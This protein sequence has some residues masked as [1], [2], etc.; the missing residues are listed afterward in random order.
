MTSIINTR[1]PSVVVT[2]TE[3]GYTKLKTRFGNV[4]EDYD[5]SSIGSW[6]YPAASTP[7][8]AIYVEQSFDPANRIVSYAGLQNS[9]AYVTTLALL[10]DFAKGS[11]PLIQAQYLVGTSD[12]LAFTTTN[13]STVSPINITDIVITQDE[14]VV[15][16]PF[17]SANIS[18]TGT[19]DLL[20]I[21]TIDLNN[22][23]AV[24]EVLATVPVSGSIVVSIPGGT[25][26][27][28]YFSTKRFSDGDTDVSAYTSF[29][30][31]IVVETGLSAPPEVTNSSLAAY[32]TKGT[33]PGYTLRVDWDYPTD[34]ASENKRRN[35]T[36]TLLANPA[37]STN[38]E[39]LNWSNAIAE[40]AIDTGYVYSS[41]PYQ[42]SY[43]IRIGVT[44]WGTEGSDYIYIPVYISKD[45]ADSGLLG[46]LIPS[47]QEYSGTTKIQI[48]DEFIRAYKVFDASN[49]ANNIKVFDVDANTGN[50]VIGTPG[51]TYNGSTMTTAPFI[52][53]STSGRLQVSGR[54]ITDQIESA[55]YVLS[56]IDATPPSLRTAGKA[57][58]AAT[59]AGIWMGYT[60]LSTFKFDLGNASNYVRWDGTD[61][62]ISGTVKIG[63]D[64]RTVGQAQRQ[65][66]VYKRSTTTPATPTDGTYS[67]PVPAGWSSVVPAGT[68]DVYM[69]SRLL[70]SDGGSPQDAVWS[71]PSLFSPGASGEVSASYTWIKYA[72]DSAGTGIS[73]SPT[74]KA[75]L[76]LS[77]NKPSPTESN[78]P[79]D[80]A[81]SQ[82]TGSTGAP[83]APG[84]DGTT[85]YIWIKYSQYAA[86]SPTMTD[87]P[88]ANTKYIGISPNR[89]TS[90][91][92]TNPA[93]YVW[94]NFKGD[95]GVPGAVTFKSTVFIR[96]TGAPSTP[97]G[98]SF[99]SPVP[100]GWSDGIPAGSLQLWASTRV[101]SEN[102]L[103]P[104]QANWTA[105]VA[106]TSTASLEI[107][108][109]T[110]TTPGDP[111]TNPTAWG[112]T[113]LENTVW[114]AQ[115]TI[116]NGVVGAWQVSKIKGETGATGS[117]GAAGAP[118]KTLILSASSQTFTYSGTPPI[119]AP[120]SQT[121]VFTATSLNT[122][123]LSW[124]T[125]PSVSLS[126]S[127]NT[128][129]LTIGDFG[130][131]SKVTV[132]VSDGVV[133][134]SV[135]VVRLEN[136]KDSVSA[137]L[138]NES[139]VVAANNA[140]GGYTLTEA[141][142]SF[143]VF[144][145]V[146]DVTSSTTFSIVGAATINGLTISINSAGVYSL[147]GASWSGTT[148]SF[149][150]RATFGS[151][152]IDKVYSISKS[153]TGATGSTGPSLRG[154]GFYRKDT[155][156]SAS[157]DGLSSSTVTSLFSTLGV[158]V[159][160]QGD[161]FVLVN[162][163][164]ET[165]A[166]SFTT[167]WAPA[168]AFIDG[169]MVVN[170]SIGAESLTA[171]VLNGKSGTITSIQTRPPG[172]ATTPRVQ[173][174]SSDAKPFSIQGLAGEDLFSVTVVPEGVAVVELKGRLAG[175]TIDSA[176]FFTRAGIDN[177]RERL[178]MPPE[179]STIE[180]FG[181]FFNFVVESA[182]LSAPT[183]YGPEGFTSPA[184]TLAMRHNTGK[185]IT[186]SARISDYSGYAFDSTGISV[187]APVWSMR[188]Q[189][190][191][192]VDGSSWT[193]WADVA[194][195]Y[196]NKT[197]FFF[198][199]NEP[200]LGPNICEFGIE[201]DYSYSFSSSTADGTYLQF[202]VQAA[203][204]SGSSMNPT[205]SQGIAESAVKVT[206]SVGDLTLTKSGTN[207]I[208]TTA[209][210]SSVNF[211]A[212]TTTQAGLVTNT[213]QV[214]SGEKTFVNGVILGNSSGYP[215]VRFA[216]IQSIGL[217]SPA[218]G[219]STVDTPLASYPDYSR[220]LEFIESAA[221]PFGIYGAFDT[222]KM[223]GNNAGAQYFYPY[224]FGA[225]AD[226]PIRYRLADY[227][228]SGWLAWRSIA[229]REWATANLLGKTG[230][231]QIISTGHSSNSD[232]YNLELYSPGPAVPGVSE[233]VSLRMH[234]GSGFWGQI[235]LRSDG[236]HFTEG[237]SGTLRNI[238][239]GT[240]TG[241][242]NGNAGSASV[243]L[244]PTVIGNLIDFSAPDS[245]TYTYWQG[246]VN[247]RYLAS[248][249]SGIKPPG[250]G[251][252]MLGM[253]LN[254]SYGFQLAGDFNSSK[255]Y[256]RSKSGTLGSWKEVIDSGNDQ[257]MG[258]VKTFTSSANFHLATQWFAA[259][260]AMQRADARS[261]DGDAGARLHWYGVST[262]GGTTNFRHSWFDGV[263]YIPVTAAGGVATFGG[264]VAA[265]QFNGPLNGNAAT[266]TKLLTARNINRVPF[267]GT[268]NIETTEWFHS[269]RDFPSGT[270]VTTSINYAV[271]EGNPW[272]LEITGNSY[273]TAESFDLKAHGYIYNDTIINV[274][275]QIEG[276]DM[277][278]IVAI[279]VGGNLC[280]WWPNY[281]YWQG[282]NV[283]VYEALAGQGINTV[284]SI[285]NSADPGG[286]KRITISD[287]LRAR[288]V[289]RSML[290]QVGGALKVP[291][292]EGSGYLMVDN[293]IRAATGTGM[294]WTHG[295][296]FFSS[297]SD[298]FNIRTPGAFSSL[299]LETNGGTVRGFLTASSDYNVGFLNDAATWSF[300]VNSSTDR[301]DFF[302][303][304]VFING[305]KIISLADL[306]YNSA[307]TQALTSASMQQFKANKD[308]GLYNNYGV[309]E[310]AIAAGY[311]NA[312]FG[313]FN[314]L[315]ANNANIVKL[316]TGAIEVSG[317][318]YALNTN[319]QFN[320]SIAGWTGLYS[321][322]GVHAT[323]GLDT[324][325]AAYYVQVYGASKVMRSDYVP[326]SVKDR[327][328]ISLWCR[329]ASGSG[330]HYLL[331][332]FLDASG[333]SVHP[334][335]GKWSYGGYEYWGLVNQAAP[336]AWTKF[337][338]VMG[339]A[340]YP[341]PATA[342][343]CAIGVLTNYSNSAGTLLD[344]QDY[345]IERAM[346]AV[347][348][349]D[350]AI[351]ANKISI[352]SSEG[353]V[354]N[355][356]VGIELN[357]SNKLSPFSI[358]VK[359]T[360]EISG[361][362][363]LFSVSKQDWVDPRTGNTSN[364]KT[365]VVVNGIAGDGFIQ[366]SYSIVEA[367]KK[368]INPDYLGGG[369][370]RSWTPGAMGSGATLTTTALVN[371][372]G[373]GVEINY[374]FSNSWNTLS[375]SS[376]TDVPPQWRVEV[377]RGTTAGTLISN[378]VYTGT[379]NSIEDREL[380][381]YEIVATISGSKT[382]SDNTPGANTTY[383]IR[384]TRL[385]AGFYAWT[386][387]Q[388]GNN[389]CTVVAFR[390]AKIHTGSTSGLVSEVMH[391]CKDT[392]FA[393]YTGRYSVT[394]QSEKTV[395]Y[396]VT[397]VEV[398]SCT[399][400]M[401][402][403]T[404]NSALTSPTYRA[405][406]TSSVII[407]NLEPNGG[408]KEV[409]FTVQ[410]RVAVV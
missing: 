34:Q 337:G 317:L 266:A 131:N 189:V 86:G 112:T 302:V 145:G 364:N 293:W 117:T 30:G 395:T 199:Y 374:N 122:G 81:W 22:P 336:A 171:D 200:E 195:S 180:I 151:V 170:G 258:G 78:D 241:T 33:T 407:R 186:V 13:L 350:G 57:A 224:N 157:V 260:T 132:S 309:A 83:G 84:V 154:A 314:F 130:A 8:S 129:Y 409:S 202:R 207:N 245:D 2:A 375:G 287:K 147:S 291:Q 214:M 196:V 316:K 100:S 223:Y 32:R 404:D 174:S 342:V 392:G 376:Y 402:A 169:N 237:S 304:N 35:F 209:N 228:G 9:T 217:H 116:T 231:Q 15:G 312:L 311:L 366:S 335:G 70:T 26:Q 359:D 300:H 56:W 284:T 175:D 226:Y 355:G 74:G 286:T 380:G 356:D 60:D 299:S 163:I 38:Y 120:V 160:M 65:F 393:T 177:L 246:G 178:A 329:Q 410:G 220:S 179:G 184:G 349:A 104:Q 382:I 105:P 346:G 321:E 283:K 294:F 167:V 11:L 61:L 251:H 275:G 377:F 203:R 301:A 79:A 121:V 69:T 183:S 118:A 99:A 372:D 297:S 219:T 369:S 173:M 77:A 73:D 158:G 140:G 259:S 368:S 172:A 252:V 144:S 347:N 406:S 268:A 334:T 14:N 19:A 278:G 340:D 399:V 80:Y 133:T 54:T 139:H 221:N 156:N 97:T 52:F 182:A 205:L 387:V 90:V 270:L 194:G 230:V 325:V 253:Q 363:N 235:R 25:Y 67:N 344:I 141:G 285:V 379:Y 318:G 264:Q 191:T 243:L 206:G 341:I 358:F 403:G 296:H 378:S 71:T 351:T 62:V 269:T 128:R 280:F 143:K 249:A 385:D 85:K 164:G 201:A 192:S 111:T 103:S 306:V 126:G 102:G 390:K 319:P 397:M 134:D 281:G 394:A 279:N 82:I 386:S 381:N 92:S 210:G 31:T 307:A 227:T 153:L 23:L 162:T 238:T 95:T 267:D 197:G 247:F 53:D 389:A 345:R 370:T 239:F 36:V 308:A 365:N 76:G 383:T 4:R 233:E 218:R 396:P 343:S 88:D 234:L 225:D 323:T 148:A 213:S 51:G 190:R 339:G 391:V 198:A 277:P 42:T 96:Q 360:S 106:M 43:V 265:N 327:Y 303:N 50:V 326:I 333:N 110:W 27:V 165:A 405:L 353:L 72:D 305:S 357:P 142:G 93:D 152:I 261:S 354:S 21:E 313:Q 59:A 155:G 330:L 109:S 324:R 18:Y 272:V 400:G 401:S 48:D 222:L 123:T 362:R 124:Y 115:R 263:S 248:S 257:V 208:L 58:F 232:A 161:S 89:D 114:M 332:N 254:A 45:T 16:N 288:P 87:E 187:A 361:T 68:D 282:F 94:S 28:R 255:L 338:M 212:A 166:Y 127:G 12:I 6:I 298:R 125:D 384:V 146:A 91:E 136:G 216:G 181:G 290:S 229:S 250:S 373:L 98:G 66:F 108:Y 149:T 119:A 39:A 244:Q 240:A 41:F 331:V 352:N 398:Y 113:A 274:G 367:V 168:T 44:G 135:G 150:L 408:I 204:T 20:T 188:T 29:P 17:A 295:N 40:V 138:T 75:Y 371:P 3:V 159:P 328:S 37:F 315:V 64:G 176:K 236:F 10:D 242:L 101:F 320:E 289:P 5:L 185:P 348:I 215:G 388:L 63:T 49:P 46:Y 107:Q 273:S 271:T 47:E 137:F 322:Y 24:W 211:D 262:T 7:A 256:T 310:G 1:P 55:S 276:L 292:Y 193:G